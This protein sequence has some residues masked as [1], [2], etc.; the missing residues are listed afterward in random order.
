M[1][2]P[3][4]VPLLLRTQGKL[5]THGHMG[6]YHTLR[7][8]VNPLEIKEVYKITWSERN[9]RLLPRGNDSRVKSQ[10]KKKR[11]KSPEK[12]MPRLGE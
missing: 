11:V 9:Q 8:I 5:D 1:G 2:K 7:W 4:Y 10:K 12:L 6:H 3:L